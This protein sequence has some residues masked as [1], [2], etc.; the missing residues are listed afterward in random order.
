MPEPV[1]MKLGMY[2]M[3]LEPITGVLHK[4]LP[5]VW[6]FV[7]L[8]L[9]SLLGKSLV[10]TFPRQR[11]HAT[12]EELDA[13]VC[14]PITIS[15]LGNK[16]VK[17][18]PRQ[19]RFVVGVVFYAVRDVSK[20]SWQLVFPR[21]SCISME[22]LSSLTGH[23]GKSTVFWNE[24]P[25]TTAVSTN[26]SDEYAVSIFRKKVKVYLYLFHFM[27]VSNHTAASSGMMICEQ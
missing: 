3:G 21:A 6:V 16:V 7:Y 17:T 26:N 1:C 25:C 15:F 10:N 9:L 27:A 23:S 14:K 13:W 12:I 4:S 5:S 8:S 18:F 24:A 20:G 19:W 2:I 11:I 22:R